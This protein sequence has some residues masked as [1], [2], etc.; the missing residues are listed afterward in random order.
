MSE[1]WHK[2]VNP[3][4]RCSRNFGIRASIPGLLDQAC[5]CLRIKGAIG[6]GLIQYG[7]EIG[8]TAGG[9]VFPIICD[10]W[11]V[12]C[13]HTLPLIIFPTGYAFLRTVA[14]CQLKLATVF[15]VPVF[16]G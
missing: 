10:R 7:I 3:T 14:A 5:L 15:P 12:D 11:Q 9:A 2:V 6:D 1:L 13:G 16:V 4:I 8:T